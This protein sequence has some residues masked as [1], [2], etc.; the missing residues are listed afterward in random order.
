VALIDGI[1][2][3]GGFGV[4]MHGSHC[5][6]GDRFRFAMP[7]VGIGFFPDVGATYLLPRL[8]GELGTYIALTGERLTGDE[9]VATGLATQRVA[10][11][12]FAE[13]LTALSGGEPVDAVLAGF[14]T[15]PGEA[16]IAARRP[17]IDRLFARDRVEDVLAALDAEAVSGSHDASW[18]AAIAATIRTKSPLSL[19]IALRQMRLGPSLTFPACMRTEFRIV[20]RIVHGHDF[21]E[22]VRAVIVDKDNAPRWQPAELGGVSAADVDRHFA[23]LGEAEL[24]LA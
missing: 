2:M 13:L 22:G 4:S 23:P 7:E 5:V 12:R 11:A 15:A 14:A 20:S 19:K 17:A 10:S 16:P 8:P 3:G 24:D 21:Y 18:A 9:A 1:V 6:A